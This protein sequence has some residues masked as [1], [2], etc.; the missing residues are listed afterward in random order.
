MALS[1][2][3]HSL[4]ACGV[5]FWSSAWRICP[6]IRSAGRQAAGRRIITLAASAVGFAAFAMFE[7]FA[8]AE[9]GPLASP[10]LPGPVCSRN[11]SAFTQ[12]P[13]RAVPERKPPAPPATMGDPEGLPRVLLIGDHGWGERSGAQT[14]GYTLAVREQLQ[15]KAN[16]HRVPDPGAHTSKGVES[17]DRWL[18]EKPWEVIHFTFGL[19]DLKRGANGQPLV[20]LEEYE[21]NLRR[22]VTRLKQ[23]GATLIWASTTPIPAGV[24]RRAPEDAV[25]Y[26]AAARKVMDD[27]AVVV[28]DLYAAALPHLTVWLAPRSV[29]FTEAGAS[30]V[31][32]HV[33]AAI[34]AALTTRTQSQPP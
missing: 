17:L 5:S 19:H 27:N 21:K 24:A 29:H 12:P 7:A 26:N 6:Q 4:C 13:A 23:T 11:N 25:R 32:K 15:G 34:E 33:A 22:I 20:P 2:I 10:V 3:S 14:V 9:N 16:V 8:Q 18:G 28:N 1:Q 31:A 30:A